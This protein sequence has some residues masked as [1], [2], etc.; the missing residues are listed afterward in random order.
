MHI[1]TGRNSAFSPSQRTAEG[2]VDGKGWFALF[3]HV[4]CARMPISG[5]EREKSPR[6]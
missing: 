2:R 4:K 1:L 3:S 5:I 6:K